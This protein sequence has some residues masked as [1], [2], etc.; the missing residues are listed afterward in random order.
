MTLADATREAR[1]IA[2]KDRVTMIVV[3]APIEEAEEAAYGRD[4]YGY[5]PA[6]AKGLLYRWGTV[7][8]TVTPLSGALPARLSRIGA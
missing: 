1:A 8:E 5:C 7:V 2:R 6:T 3:H 4:C